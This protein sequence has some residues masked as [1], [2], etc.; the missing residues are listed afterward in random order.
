[1]SGHNPVDVVLL[2]GV[3]SAGK[4]SIARALQAITREMFLH[5]QMDSFLEMMPPGSFGHPDGFIFETLPVTP[6]AV[7]IH[8]GPAARRVM[9]G[10]RHSIK[11]LADQG[12]HLIVDDVLTTPDQHAAYAALLAGHRL[13]SVAVHA[14][15]D[16]LEAREAARGDR[17]IGL[18]RWQF[19]RV[20]QGVAYDLSV[21]SSTATPGEC[22]EAIRRVFD[23]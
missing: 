8:T 15:L 7:A 19:P 16:V 6:P 5:V 14:P 21:D 11:A 9:A 1:M 2:N 4:S 3:T 22:A 10:M 23:L 13:H 17:L 12:N 20:H 18:A